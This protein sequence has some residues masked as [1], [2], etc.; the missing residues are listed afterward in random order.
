MKK[1]LGSVTSSAEYTHCWPTQVPS[2]THN[3]FFS[4]VSARGRTL[5]DKNTFHFRTKDAFRPGEFT[6]TIR[7][8]QYRDLLRAEK[9]TMEKH[10]DPA[11]DI[12]AAQVSCHHS[13]YVCV[14]MPMRATALSDCLVSYVAL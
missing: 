13:V 8:E 11:K 10:R 1:R 12:A 2:S 5:C 14:T 6:A 7:T 4:P 3:L 9:V